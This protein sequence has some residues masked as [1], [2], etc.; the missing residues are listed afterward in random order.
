MRTT[1]NG[2]SAFIS[3]LR[4]TQFEGNASDLAREVGVSPQAVSRWISHGAV[5]RPDVLR[6]V[7]TVTGHDLTQL[8]D[9]AHGGPVEAELPAAIPTP[10]R[11]RKTTTPPTPTTPATS[12]PASA[13]AMAA[14]IPPGQLG[15]MLARLDDDLAA[16][17]L[18]RRTWKA[19][20]D[21]MV[22]AAEIQLAKLAAAKPPDSPTA[23]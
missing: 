12:P 17:R 19:V 7:A 15:A 3:R 10:S 2:W 20:H 14:R 5:P 22:L 8:L 6:R 23:P 1:L 13:T 9:I 16:G 21:S 4:D 18:N 11:T